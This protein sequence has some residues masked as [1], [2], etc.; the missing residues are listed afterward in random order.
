M[1][2]ELL[3]GIEEIWESW[4]ERVYWHMKLVGEE[5]NNLFEEAV[6]ESNIHLDL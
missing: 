2:K 5:E 3:N 4:E 6:R 1:G